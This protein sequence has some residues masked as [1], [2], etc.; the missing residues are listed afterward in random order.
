M[1]QHKRGDVDVWE[2]VR[3]PKGASLDEWLALNTMEIFEELTM[4][5]GALHGICTDERCP[6]MCAGRRL[7][8]WGEGAKAREPSRLS[9]PRYFKR[10][11]EWVQEQLLDESLFP[12]ARGRP[13]PQ[14]FHRTVG[15]IFRRLF[16]L[17]A[18]TY[19]SHYKDLTEEHADV[20][21][22]YAFKYFF[23]FVQE[24][25]L[26]ED[27]TCEPLK[28]MVSLLK[29][30]KVTAEAKRITCKPCK[31]QLHEVSCKPCNEDRLQEVS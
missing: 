12:V 11:L 19:H 3:V 20:Q 10:C 14:H 23:F 31:D 21:L 8:S 26:I 25:R 2:I 6:R 27:D 13:F 18:H 22:N 1:L 16:R 29:Q 9:A 28:E 4:L 15:T 17:Y 5:T 7:Y 24:F 30:Q